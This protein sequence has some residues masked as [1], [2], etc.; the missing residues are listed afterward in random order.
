MKAIRD[1]A[2]D[3]ETSGDSSRIASNSVQR[4]MVEMCQGINA[5]MIYN[6]LS[7]RANG[8]HDINCR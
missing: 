7:V 1:V 3:R 5:Q 2:I 6:E 4:V 8:G